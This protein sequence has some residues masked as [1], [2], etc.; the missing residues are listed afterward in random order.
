MNDL[1]RMETLTNLLVYMAVTILKEDR[2]EV[3]EIYMNG[4]YIQEGRKIVT[5]CT[6]LGGLVQCTIL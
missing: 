6:V 4:C 1:E 3:H 2:D 5:H